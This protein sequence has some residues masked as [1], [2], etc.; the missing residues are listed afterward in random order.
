L[1]RY[2]FKVT[3]YSNL[4][5]NKAK[6]RKGY[7]MNALNVK[8]N[9]T[10]N[11]VANVPTKNDIAVETAK[12]V[13]DFEKAQNALKTIVAPTKQDLQQYQSNSE[14]ITSLKEKNVTLIETID[15][16]LATNLT[17][18]KEAGKSNK[19]AFRIMF[20]ALRS[21]MIITGDKDYTKGVINAYEW[22][23][24]SNVSVKKRVATLKTFKS[25]KSLSG[26]YSNK[27][28]NA[29]MSDKSLTTL[30]AYKKALDARLTT[31]NQLKNALND[32]LTLTEAQ[33]LE[34]CKEYGLKHSDKKIKPVDSLVGDKVATLELIA[35]VNQYRN[36]NALKA[37]KE[38]AKA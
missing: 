20:E 30:E 29:L 3:F 7:K 36:E 11:E 13:A 33:Q 19:Q 17:P 24:M 35:K 28:I 16:Y 26:Y 37:L 23:Y 1:F 10:L 21:D 18:L 6:S 22:Y 14:E 25:L 4:N 15:H 12:L 38:G 32:L 34:V 5:L 9:D 2:Y 31:A 27:A 8:P